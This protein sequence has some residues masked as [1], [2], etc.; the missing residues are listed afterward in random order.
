MDGDV[1][2]CGSLMHKSGYCDAIERVVKA[3]RDASRAW[4]FKSNLHPVEQALLDALDDLATL[5]GK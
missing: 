3:A 4:W 5:E 2:R 1:C